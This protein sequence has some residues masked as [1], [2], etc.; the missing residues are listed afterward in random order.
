MV[1]QCGKPFGFLK[2]LNVQLPY[3]KK[4]RVTMWATYSTSRYIPPKIKTK[5]ETHTC[6]PVLTAGLFTI[7]KVRNNPNVH[8]RMNR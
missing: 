4:K 1:K 8:Q 2:K 3:E 6:T 5:T 7:T